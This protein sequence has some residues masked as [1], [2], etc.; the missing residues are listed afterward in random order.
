[1]PIAIR[2]GKASHALAGARQTRSKNTD[3]N[4][5]FPEDIGWRPSQERVHR[6]GQ[7]INWTVKIILSG[8]RCSVRGG[9]SQGSFGRLAGAASFAAGSAT[10]STEF[11]TAGPNRAEVSELRF[12]CTVSP[13]S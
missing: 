2:K 7:V 6:A 8:T 13:G 12:T 5:W 1:M 4:S 3:E 9:G 11:S 10:G